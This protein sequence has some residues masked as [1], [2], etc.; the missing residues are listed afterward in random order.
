ML[1][2]TSSMVLGGGERRKEA[3]HP[4]LEVEPPPRNDGDVAST[5]DRLRVKIHSH[6]LTLIASFASAIRNDEVGLVSLHQTLE[7]IIAKTRYHLIMRKK[8]LK[9]FRPVKT[10]CDK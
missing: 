8:P 7:V 2:K 3:A 1:P 5:R 6:A 10:A 9:G 4:S